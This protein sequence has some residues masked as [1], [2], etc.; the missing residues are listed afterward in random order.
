MKHHAI[1]AQRHN[2]SL[3]NTFILV[4]MV[5]PL[6][7][8]VSFKLWLLYYGQKIQEFRVIPE[9]GL[10][11]VVEKNCIARILKLGRDE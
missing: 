6:D 11:H 2:F 1:R 10:D 8:G 3:N 5:L 4:L 9:A 7:G